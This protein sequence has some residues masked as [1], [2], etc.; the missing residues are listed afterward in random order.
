MGFTVKCGS[1]SK[2][3]CAGCAAI[4]YGDWVA[5]GRSGIVGGDAGRYSFYFLTL[6]APSF[7]AV[8]RVPKSAESNVQRCR[9]GVVHTVEDVGLRGV[10][11]DPETYDYAGQVAWNRDAGVLWS[12]TVRRLRDVWESVE[13]F[14]VREW[15]ARGVLHVHVLLR[16]E[17][18]ERAT[19]E[20][21]RMRAASAVAWSKVDGSLVEWGQEG[22]DC[23]PIRADGDAQRRAWYIAKALNYS[24][25]DVVLDAAAAPAAVS[26]HQNRLRAAAERMRCS[27]LCEGGYC[28]SR[29]HRNYG[30]RGHV[31]S[32][33]R[34]TLTRPGWSFTGLTRTRLRRERFLWW[35]LNGAT[36]TEREARGWPGEA[37]V[38]E[39]A[40]VAA[41]EEVAALCPGGP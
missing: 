9:C 23:Q 31:V 37:S 19:S 39:S 26:A 41:R 17:L 32:A 22:T 6:T 16:V 18:R 12:N 13:F 2:A 4:Y 35:L 24:L 5:I 36:P 21:V 30:A 40:A 8:H 15:Q 14:M 1:R 10:P 20:A 29:A 11:I 38:M 7:G 27:A 34:R 25:K 3:R 28:G 33:S